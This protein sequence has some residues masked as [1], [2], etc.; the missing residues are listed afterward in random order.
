MER[1]RPEP[2]AKSL[3]IFGIFLVLMIV[4]IIAVAALLGT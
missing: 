4:T 1:D 3:V 2:R